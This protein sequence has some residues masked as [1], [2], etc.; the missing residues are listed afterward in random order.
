[1][2]ASVARHV[3]NAKMPFEFDTIVP[4]ITLQMQKLFKTTPTKMQS[5]FYVRTYF[6]SSN[7]HRVTFLMLKIRRF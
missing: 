6:V 1:M 5:Q 7:K 2:G 4:T 3:Y